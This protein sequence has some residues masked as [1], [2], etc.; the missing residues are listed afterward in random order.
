[1]IVSS[2]NG[3]VQLL[4][5]DSKVRAVSD[6]SDADAVSVEVPASTSFT[7]SSSSGAKS[8]PQAAA[9]GSLVNQL[10]ITSPVVNHPPSA[11]QSVSVFETAE[12]IKS[13]QAAFLTAQRGIPPKDSETHSDVKA[14]DVSPKVPLTMQ[15]LLTVA[16]NTT[17]TAAKTLGNAVSYAVFGQG[18]ISGIIGGLSNSGQG[19]DN[20]NDNITKDGTDNNNDNSKSKD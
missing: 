1:L 8:L 13:A 7:S 15:S 20:N 10:L 18:G 17:V 3:S 11:K 19:N 2:V 16:G 6:A 5:N 14:A 9:K 4:K 12:N